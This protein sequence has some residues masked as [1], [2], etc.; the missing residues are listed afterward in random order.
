MS[1]CAQ[2]SSRELSLSILPHTSTYQNARDSR[3]RWNSPE[4]RMTYDLRTESWIPFARSSGATEWGPPDLIV[5][6]IATN[7]VVAFASPRPDFDGAL[8]E[9]LIGLLTAAFRLNN[10]ESW[11]KLWNTPPSR[12]ELRAALMALPPAFDLDGDG[13]RFLQDFTPS[14]LADA[15]IAPVQEILVEG[16]N[17]PLFIKPNTLRQLGRPA[18]AMALITIQSY[19]PAGGRGYRTSLRGGGPLTTL[20]DP[21]PDESSSPLDRSLWRHLWANVSTL[22]ELPGWVA[23][24]NPASPADTFPWMAPTRTSERDRATSIADVNPLQCFF[25]MPRRITLEFSDGPGR[26][27]LTGRD[28]QRVVTGFRVKGYGV[29]YQGWR[30]PLTPYYAGKAENEWLPLHGQPGGIGWRDW[31]PL[32]HMSATAI[33]I[34]ARVVAIFNDA[35]ADRVGRLRYSLH[36]FGF[37]VTNAKTRSW[38]DA[39]L[40]AFVERDPE[41]LELMSVLIASLTS[42]TELAAYTLHRTVIAALYGGSAAPA[43]D[44]SFIKAS[45]WDATE[46]EFYEVVRRAVDSSDLA[47]ALPNVRR[48]FQ[49]LLLAAAEEIFDNHVSAGADQPEQLRRAVVARFDL[50]TTLRGGGKP[51]ERFF[52]ALGLSTPRARRA[53]SAARPV[54]QETTT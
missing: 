41:R 25:G 22:E 40:P 29:Q 38:I 6:A 18:A 13:P 46:L 19:S 31:L 45:L 37:D 23:G 16:K 52:E 35:R 34:P 2:P 30:H 51:G 4:E 26:C 49:K 1:E 8:S 48:D 10:E 44:L 21:R 50:V 5:D 32:I 54:A 7:P 20:V 14:D 28:D 47:G 9:F 24:R 17:D 27:D 53:R 12:D 3:W 33:K 36:T 11:R 42:A 39:R 43:G 15:E